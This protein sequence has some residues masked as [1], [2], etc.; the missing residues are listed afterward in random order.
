M[1]ISQD[2]GRDD[3]FIRLGKRGGMNKIGVLVEGPLELVGV[4]GSL[5]SNSQDTLNTFSVVL[6]PWIHKLL[7]PVL[8]QLDQCIVFL[9]SLVSSARDVLSPWW[10]VVRNTYATNLLRS[11]IFAIGLK[12]K[13]VRLG[14]VELLSEGAVLLPRLL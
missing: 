4:C 6:Q 9:Y 7:N 8:D 12:T 1:Q 13:N 10:Q 11:Q 2:N 3:I 14:I 5:S